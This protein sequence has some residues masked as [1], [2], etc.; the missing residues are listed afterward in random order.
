MGDLATYPECDGGCGFGVE[1]GYRIMVNGKSLLICE[2]CIREMK[3]EQKS[4]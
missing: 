3:Y 2:D 4:V 1:D